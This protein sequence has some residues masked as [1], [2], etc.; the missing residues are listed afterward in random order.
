MKATKHCAFLTMADL[1]GFVSYDALTYQPLQELGWTVEE[2][3]WNR[4][5]VQWKAFDAVVIR[6]TWDYQKQPDAF[7]GVLEIIEI[8]GTPL[9]NSLEYCRWN[10]NKTYLRDLE[11]KG[12]RILPTLWRD[13]IQGENPNEWFEQLH[14]DRIVIK[15]TIGANADDTL[16]LSDNRANG[17]AE[18]EAIFQLRPLMVQPYVASI[19]TIGE[20]SLFYFGGQYSHAVNK[21]PK[22]G[23][24]RVQEEHGGIIQS[25]T[26]NEQ[27]MQYGQ[28][29]M[30]QMGQEL[31]YARVDLVQWEGQPAV[32]EVEL[33]EPSLYFAFDPESPRRFAMAL[34]RMLK[35]A[36]F[37]NRR[38]LRI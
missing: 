10:M 18:I 2:I 17:F 21:K 22:P 30:D 27:L 25:I 19:E 23:D 9:F 6:S 13:S 16:V 37:P 31:L 5:G 3:P 4:A 14:S 24:F 35:P 38:G 32:M 34:D 29:V 7:L 28:F 15:P 33:I 8:H 11:R 26:A 20:F 36:V 1:S 12:V